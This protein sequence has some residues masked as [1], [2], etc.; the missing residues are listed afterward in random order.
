MEFNGDDS[1][2]TGDKAIANGFNNFFV[3]I[4]PSLA[5]RIP[6]CN[7]ILFT[8]YLPDKIDDTMFLQPVTEEE[9][10]QLVVNAKSKKSK[11]HDQFDM[12]L[13]K[14]IIPHIVKPLAHICNTSLMNGIF[15]DR[16]KIARVVPLFK[17]GDVKEFSNYRPVS[18]LSQFSKILEKVFHNRLMSFIN[19]KQILNN[20]QFGFR[21]NMSTAMAIIELVE[22]I[23]T[24]IDE[25][26]TT[27]GVGCSL[28]LKKHSI[29]SIIIS[30][31]RNWN[32]MELED[33]LK[34]G[35]VVTS[36]TEGNMSAL[37]IL[38]LIVWTLNVECHR[39]LY[40]GQHCLFCMLMICVMSQNL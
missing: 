29:R 36:R 1:K 5:K 12:C 28:I 23:T 31:P 16:M 21:K 11:D 40:W 17:N 3:N 37:M 38:T 6:K 32:T 13:V 10:L 2:I 14:K 39:A 25:G 30:W 33:W 15:P 7:D 26:K 35:S 27:V 20:S 24:A 8:Q 19:D 9:I 22:E 4:G 18:I 34:I